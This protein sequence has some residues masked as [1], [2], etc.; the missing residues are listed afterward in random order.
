[1][2]LVFNFMA[3]LN[4]LIEKNYPPRFRL[5]SAMYLS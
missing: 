5:E 1:M 2:N 4:L 3:A